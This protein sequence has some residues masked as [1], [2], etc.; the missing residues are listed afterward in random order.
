MLG[1][2]DDKFVWSNIEITMIFPDYFIAFMHLRGFLIIIK[3]WSEFL[4]EE[5]ASLSFL[6]QICCIGQ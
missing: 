1:R 2:V 3:L 5:Y 4:R 6:E